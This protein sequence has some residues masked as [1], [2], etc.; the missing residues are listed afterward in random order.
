MILSRYFICSEYKKLVCKARAML[1]VGDSI[2]DIILTQ[3]HNHPPQLDASV[4]DLFVREIK[5]VIF[6]DPHK[7]LREIYNFVSSV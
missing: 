5:N 4:K 6:K 2:K 7:P 3:E 1:P